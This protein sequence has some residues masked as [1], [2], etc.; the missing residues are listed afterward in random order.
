MISEKDTKKVTY[1]SSIL[2]IFLLIEEKDELWK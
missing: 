2:I 1:I